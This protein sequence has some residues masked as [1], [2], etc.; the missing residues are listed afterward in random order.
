MV[1]CYR[2]EGGKPDRQPEFTQLD[3]EMSFASRKDIINLIEDLLVHCW[4]REVETPIEQMVYDDA[5]SLY[6]VDKPDLRFDNK[7]INLTETLE[8][9]GFDFIDS[10]SGQ[11]KFYFSVKLIQL[12]CRC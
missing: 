7:I 9:S 10:K 5:M 4:P 12:L 8:N 11:V 3:I 2:D 6:G 1:R